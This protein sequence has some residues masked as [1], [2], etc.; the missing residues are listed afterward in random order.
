MD[1][2]VEVR[3]IEV[4]GNLKTCTLVAANAMKTA[5]KIGNQAAGL[6]RIEK[7]GDANENAL[8][9]IAKRLITL[10]KTVADL[11]KQVAKHK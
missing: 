4:E 7:K 9:L 5:Y 8:E 6:Q 1:K 2:E 10:E 11:A 3:F